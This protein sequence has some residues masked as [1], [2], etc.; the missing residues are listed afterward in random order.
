LLGW[1]ALLS[2][3]E[4]V[5][6]ISRLASDSEL[7]LDLSFNGASK[8]LLDQLSDQSARIALT[9]SQFWEKN[10]IAWIQFFR[11]DV[12]LTCPELVRRSSSLSMGLQFT[13]DSTIKALN[14]CWRARQEKT[15][16][17]SFPMLDEDIVFP[18]DQSLE[19]G[20]IVV[21]VNTAES[22]AKEEN[23]S[24]ANELLWLVSH[25]LMHLLGWD[26]P[27]SDRLEEM[28]KYQEQLLCLNGNL[29]KQQ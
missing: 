12:S 26:H 15:D 23:H 1:D 21:S 24:L 25:G 13:D 22:Q 20:D 16:V 5:M 2:R 4:V 7:E 6:D 19:I 14:S 18:K 9:E 28:L 8:N 27:N 17:L 11:C 10:L 29:L 3:I